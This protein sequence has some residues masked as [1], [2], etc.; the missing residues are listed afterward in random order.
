M[1]VW[2][3]IA[4]YENLYQISNLGNIKSLGNKKTRKDKILKLDLH[5]NGYYFIKLSKNGKPK[6]FMVHRLV[7]NNFL[8][9]IIGKEYINHI[10]GIKTDNRVENLEWCTQQ[11]NIKH[12]WANGLS[13]IHNTRKRAS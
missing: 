1:E 12:S 9:K 5:K 8:S 13:K 4:G 6:N 11:Y 10:N 3:D 7:C 2:K